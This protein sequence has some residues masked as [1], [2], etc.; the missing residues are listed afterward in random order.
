MG[1]SQKNSPRTHRLPKA[2]GVPLMRSANIQGG[3]GFTLIELLVVI[4]IIGILAT[5]VMAS[6]SSARKRGRDAR[7]ISD[8]KQLQLALEL[9]YDANTTYPTALSALTGPGYI[10]AIPNDPGTLNP[11]A[12]VALQGAAAAPSTCASY[13]LGAKLENNANVAAAGSPFNDDSDTKGAGTYPTDDG[14]LCSG[15]IQTPPNS[16]WAGSTEIPPILNGTGNDFDG[17]ND[18]TNLVYDMR[19]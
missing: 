19:P 2:D 6:L 10:A 8:I 3:R 9:Y 17:T 14:T 4:A 7:R 13:H 18:A 12:Y 11:Y 1:V 5:I 15:T 16:S